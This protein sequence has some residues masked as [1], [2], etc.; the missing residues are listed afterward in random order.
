M[1]TDAQGMKYLKISI[2]WLALVTKKKKN[3]EFDIYT[4][5]ISSFSSENCNCLENLRRVSSKFQIEIFAV[6]SHSPIDLSKASSLIIVNIRRTENIL[7]DFLAQ[8]RGKD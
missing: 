6:H 4:V 2:V 1:C 8:F 3:I 5:A 7:H